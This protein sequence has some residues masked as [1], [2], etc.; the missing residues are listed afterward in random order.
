M[1]E[2][3]SPTLLV[4]WNELDD[5]VIEAAF[6]E[7]AHVQASANALAN[8]VGRLTSAEHDP[9]GM[10]RRLSRA[11]RK[12]FRQGLRLDRYPR[13]FV[14]GFKA[15]PPR[16]ELAK[17]QA[18]ARRLTVLR[19]LTELAELG[20]HDRAVALTLATFSEFSNDPQFA[21]RAVQVFYKAGAISLALAATSA[22]RFG[23]PSPSLITRE[24]GLLGRI[25]ETTEGWSPEL[26]GPAEPL[27]QLTPGR[28]L[29][30]LKESVPYHENGFTMR[31]MYTLQAQL[32]A[33]LE[34]IVLTSLGF[35]RV[36]GVDEFADDEVVEGI[37]HIRL[38][39][40]PDYDLK[41]PYD[42][43]LTDFTWA[44]ARHV[45]ELAPSVIHVGSGHRGYETALV[46]LALGRH[47]G[48][49]VVY[50]VRSFFETTW[51]PDAARAELGEYY[52]RR[53]ETENRC[54]AAADA[55][56]TISESMRTEIASRGIPLDRIT[57][58][59]NGVDTRRFSPRERSAELIDRYGLR[60]RFVFGYVSNLDHPREGQE[61]L[62]QA[63][64]ILRDRGVPATALIVGDGR[65]RAELEGLAEGAGDAVV[66][67]GRVDHREVLDHYALMSVF[68]VPRTRDRAARLVTPLKP[69]EAMAAGIPL[70]VS[71][72]EALREIIG[73]GDRGWVFPPGD[74]HALADLLQ[75]LSTDPSSLGEKAERGLTWV[76]EL[77]QWS[78][79]GP[80]YQSAYKGLQD[81]NGR[82]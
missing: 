26:P 57:V 54:M 18:A 70:V 12:A 81:Q 66:F 72:L 15:K 40:G 78:A 64:Q 47:F 13:A 21:S 58:A 46:G 25:R 69:F 68:V 45:R 71:D 50:E 32:E 35:P 9:N 39:L 43:Y 76:R 29:H 27:Q 22:L 74:A 34:P 4:A 67:T 10:P 28:V 6:A 56:M 38:D 17:A 82:G 79:N 20:E 52:R 49:P 1:P 80:I 7:L 41:S 8:A 42:R 61:T 55:V 2:R 37:R 65:R 3:P 36:I 63:A 75:G 48:I 62:I 59:P 24:A 44:A 53:Y 19:R 5:A 60:D 73:D 14:R 30:L 77:R 31:S 33:G 11:A 23:D 51:T 16:T